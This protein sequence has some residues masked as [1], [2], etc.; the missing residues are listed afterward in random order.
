M[1]VLPSHCVLVRK[2][3]E[4]AYSWVL[5][6]NQ[7]GFDG[8]AKHLEVLLKNPHKQRRYCNRLN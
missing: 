2:R 1:A 7:D 6:K 5:L 4:L 8:M 3:R